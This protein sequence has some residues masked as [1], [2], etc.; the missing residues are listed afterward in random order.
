MTFDGAV[1]KERAGAGIW[2]QLP[3]GE[4]LSYSYKFAY[5]C[6]KNEAE[7]EALMLVIQ[8]LKSFQVKKAL[9]HRDSELV[10]K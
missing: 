3:D 1:C 7:Y 10:I 6:T 2:M 8:I 4:V 5:E 9:I